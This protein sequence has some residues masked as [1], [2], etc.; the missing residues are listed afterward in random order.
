[1]RLWGRAASAEKLR[2]ALLT[3]LVCLS[4]PVWPDE[5]TSS[6]AYAAEMVTDYLDSWKNVAT[7]FKQFRKCDDG[8]VAEGFSDAVARLLADHWDQLPALVQIAGSTPGL[9][10][11]VLR[12]LNE[13]TNLSD[14]QKIAKLARDSC[15]KSADSLCVKIAAKLRSI[16]G[17]GA[18]GAAY[19][20]VGG[21]RDAR[22]CRRGSG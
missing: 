22:W 9:E 6:A 21:S 16:E 1:M 13:T 5:C 4:T 3:A 20:I 11:F 10:G 17:A 2:Y 18:S 7:A 14:V 8:V 15:P 19:P 12:H